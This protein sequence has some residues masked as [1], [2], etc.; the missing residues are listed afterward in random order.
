MTTDQSHPFKGAAAK[1]PTA[2]HRPAIWECMLGTVYA[3]DDHGEVRYF[4]YRWDDAREFAGVSPD[5]DPRVAKASS[6][7]PVGWAMWALPGN[8]RRRQQA[9]WLLK[10]SK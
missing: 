5:R 8:L 2:K 9:L 3:M 6:A 4:D 10:E 1:P 7:N